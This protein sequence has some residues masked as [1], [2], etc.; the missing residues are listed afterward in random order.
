M[1]FNIQDKYSDQGLQFVSISLHDDEG[2]MSDF[3]KDYTLNF[4]VLIGGGFPSEI[5]KEYGIIA[6]PHLVFIDRDNY[7]RH[8]HRGTWKL[9]QIEFFIKD[10][11]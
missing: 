5:S 2:Q 8:E 1:Q 10:L 11:L 6:I 3:L 9:E 7:I 4:P